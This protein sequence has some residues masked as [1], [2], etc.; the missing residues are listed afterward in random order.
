[1]VEKREVLNPASE[2]AYELT[3]L[4]QKLRICALKR[5]ELFFGNKKLF[6]TVS[7]NLQI[8]LTSL[9]EA[10]DYFSANSTS[11]IWRIRS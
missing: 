4:T 5:N 8:A 10:N 9:I 6:N 11:G 3:S 2:Y 7:Q 1:V